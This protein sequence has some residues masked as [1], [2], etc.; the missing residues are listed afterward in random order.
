[1]YKDCYNHF[2][3]TA[4]Q[5]QWVCE[6]MRSDE[7]DVEDQWQAGNRERAREI[8][9]D[10]ARERGRIWGAALKDNRP[11]R[12]QETTETRPARS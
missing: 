7:I 6:W 3:A 5:D 11:M 8:Q 2:A 4:K 10:K 12:T 9:R 1:M